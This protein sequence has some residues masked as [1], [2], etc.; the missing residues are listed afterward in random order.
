VDCGTGRFM[1]T[2]LVAPGF[3]EIVM[4]ALMASSRHGSGQTSSGFASCALPGQQQ[5]AGR[6]RHFTQETLRRWGLGGIVEDCA[7]IVSELLSNAVRYGLDGACPG[8]LPLRLAL[9]RR[10]SSVT[11]AISDLSSAPPVLREPD[12]LA[13][14]GRGLHI[15]DTLAQSWGWTVPADRSGKTVWA[16]VAFLK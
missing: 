10:S 1:T 2:A 12:W 9:W 15:V 16:S 4:T 7:V 11:C 8:M 5:S 14:S 3:A 6:A 13:E